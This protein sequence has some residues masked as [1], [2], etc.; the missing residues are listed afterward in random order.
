MLPS[1]GEGSAGHDKRVPRAFFLKDDPTWVRFAVADRIPRSEAAPLFRTVIQGLGLSVFR[2][3]DAPE[4]AV[5]R[6]RTIARILPLEPDP[7]FPPEYREASLLVLEVTGDVD[8][9]RAFWAR[10]GL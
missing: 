4:D 5:L 1:T 3:P 10:F 2:D 9:A 6:D 7:S 8:A